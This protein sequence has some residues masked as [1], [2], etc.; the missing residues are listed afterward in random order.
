[1]W[2]SKERISAAQFRTRVTADTEHDFE[3]IDGE[4]V[5]LMPTFGYS[6][7][8][9]ARFATLIGMYLLEHDI[10]HM[11]DAQGGYD[12]DDDNTYALDVGIILKARL[13]TLPDN[14]YIPLPPDLVVEVVSVSDLQHARERI[15]A[16]RERYLAA[17][18]RL[19]IY[20][21]P[22]R[23]AVDVYRSGQAVVT[24]DV[25]DSLDLSEVLP[26][27]VIAVRLLFP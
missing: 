21:Y 16:K 12:I 13:A 26:G 9:S 20:A 2:T 1:M 15:D 8:V 22:E 11:T 3:L 17:G 7:S 19:V 27:L 14:A 25:A 6:S 18:V 24:L 4:M 23:Q 10:A 5:E